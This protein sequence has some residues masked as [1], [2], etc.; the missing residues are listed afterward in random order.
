MSDL[1]AWI[2]LWFVVVAMIVALLCIV[3]A[4]IVAIAQLWRRYGHVSFPNII[5]SNL[6]LIGSSLSFFIVDYWFLL[7][8]MIANWH[9]NDLNS[10]YDV[11]NVV[12]L[13]LQTWLLIF[14]GIVAYRTYLNGREFKQ[15][16]IEAE[17][18]RRYEE[19]EHLRQS[20]EFNLDPLPYVKRYWSHQIHQYYMWNRNLISNELYMIWLQG[21]W[22]NFLQN[23]NFGDPQNN[24]VIDYRS[25]FEYLRAQEHFLGNETFVR[26][27][28]EIAG[29]AMRGDHLFGHRE[30][31]RYR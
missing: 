17:C 16:D 13:P 25:G 19:I 15:R 21:R 9:A 12:F 23:E 22:L 2:I 6:L 27:M 4:G 3:V 11:V 28:S 8:P 18:V 24:T 5:N 30:L 7:R 29:R 14:A 20:P 1:I 26:L 31:R 10:L